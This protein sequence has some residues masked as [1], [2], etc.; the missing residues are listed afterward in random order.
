MIWSNPRNGRVLFISKIT[1]NIICHANGTCERA[2]IGKP[3]KSINYGRRNAFDDLFDNYGRY[4]AIIW[5][6]Y[7]TRTLRPSPV[8][9]RRATGTVGTTSRCRHTVPGTDNTRRIVELP[10]GF[11]RHSFHSCDNLP[12]NSRKRTFFV[13]RVDRRS[14]K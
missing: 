11:T 12:A 1:T 14:G 7:K 13:V 10:A 2:N 4:V 9:R 6:G 8:V 3:T 5:P